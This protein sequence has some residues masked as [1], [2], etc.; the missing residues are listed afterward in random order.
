MVKGSSTAIYTRTYLGPTFGN[1]YDISVANNASYNTKSYARF[2]VAYQLPSKV[3]NR[4]TVLAG[5]LNFTPDEVEVFYLAWT[6][7]GLQ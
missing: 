1:G 3:Q 7:K 6:T 4:E 2:G 5:S